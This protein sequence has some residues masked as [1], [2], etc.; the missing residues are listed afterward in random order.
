MKKFSLFPRMGLSLLLSPFVLIPFIG[1]AQWTATDGSIVSDANKNVGIGTSTPS[2]PN[3][4]TARLV[5]KGGVTNS[6][7]NIKL[8]G[9]ETGAVEWVIGTSA[10]GWVAGGG[11]FLINTGAANAST[12]SPFAIVAATG[13]VGIG[14]TAPPAAYKLAVAGKVIAEEVV[15]KLQ[16]NWPDYVFENT[17]TL[18][19][20]LEVERYIRENKHL[21]GIPSAQEVQQNG[22]TVGEMNALLLKKI[23]ELTLY[24][25]DLKKESVESQKKVAALQQEIE[26]LKDKR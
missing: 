15:I 13:N 23:E 26:A 17:Y 6:D 9:A 18:P 19:P 8:T 10:N 16:T 5:V 3:S 20:L 2:T 24:V 11:K 14:T 22:L 4:L 25:V 21:P 1:Q 12:Q 7:W